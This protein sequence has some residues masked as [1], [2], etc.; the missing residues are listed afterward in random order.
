MS[1]SDHCADLPDGDCRKVEILYEDEWLAV[2]FK[3][4]GLLSVPAPGCG[5][6]AQAL[7]EN[8]MRKTGKYSPRHRPFAVHRLDRETSGV[9][10]FALN[11][12][13]RK[14]IMDNWRQIVT[15]R[16]YRAVAENPRGNPLAEAGTIA[17]PLA[18]NA[19]HI[20]YVPQEQGLRD[21]GGETGR[22]ND[23]RGGYDG[24]RDNDCGGLRHGGRRNQRGGRRDAAPRENLRG[25]FGYAERYS[26]QYENDDF[27][28]IR[29]G[30]G[31]SGQTGRPADRL[32]RRVV[33][34]H[35]RAVG[36]PERGGKMPERGGADSPLYGDTRT[37]RTTKTVSAVT[38]YRILARGETYSL[39]ELSLETGRKNQIRAHLA[40]EGYPLAG[41]V[42][43]RAKT[44]PFGRLALHART[45]AF[46]HPFTGASLEFEIPEP[47]KW[48]ETVIAKARPE[49]TRSQKSPP[50]SGR[51]R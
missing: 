6:S 38:H 13:A 45:L 9:M 15:A 28:G 26:E 30:G 42:N 46:V 5:H 27:G 25:G 19:Y 36:L 51:P 4:A 43:Y 10:M 21:A 50:R 40:S 18:F 39:F 48:R 3:P 16:L 17:T 32:R 7:L 20:A 14:K 23:R 34:M 24:G 33:E 12:I 35:G 49:A 22:L 31:R 37:G 29:Q 47:E 1:F 11:R 44:D 8:L 41:D 2:I